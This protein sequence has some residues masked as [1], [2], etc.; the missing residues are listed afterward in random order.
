MYDVALSVMSCVRAGTEVHVAWTVDPSSGSQAVAF[1]PGGGKMGDLWAGAFDHALRE[2]IA[3]VGP[4]GGLVPLD[5]GPAEALVSG[6]GEQTK[7]VAAVAPGSSIPEAALADLV[8]RRPVVFE[9]NLAGEDVVC[10]FNPVP[11]A[12]ISGAGE[13]ADA[14][15][16]VFTH[17]GWAVTVAPGVETAGGLMATLAQIDAAIVLGHDVEV[18]SRALEAAIKSNAGYIASVGSR[19]MQEAREQWL[20]YQGVDW[21]ERVHGPAGFNI[22]ASTPGEIAVSIAAEAIAFIRGTQELSQ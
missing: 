1:T 16:R 5:V 9:L 15:E 8:D 20:A 3:G 4:D 13:I 12:V 17:A 14:L 22:G 18:S 21:P 19:K 10:S 2:A 11:R 6:L 7:V